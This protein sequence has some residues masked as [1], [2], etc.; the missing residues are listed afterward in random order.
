M[1]TAVRKFRALVFAVR[2][3]LVVR[4]YGRLMARQS[5]LASDLVDFDPV[6]AFL[7]DLQ[8]WTNVE[9]FAHGRVQRIAAA[10]LKNPVARPAPPS[11]EEVALEARRLAAAAVAAL[12]QREES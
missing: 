3:L 4:L 8:F 11:D 6:A 9:Q 1:K 5:K 7:Y 2:A 12:R 10:V